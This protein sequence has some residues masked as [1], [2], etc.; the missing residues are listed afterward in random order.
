MY[1]VNA[2]GRTFN[3]KSYVEAKDIVCGIAVIATETLCR[4]LPQRLFRSPKT[5]AKVNAQRLATSNNLTNTRI[6][7]PKTAG[8]LQG[9][10]PGLRYTITRF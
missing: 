8:S 9:R 5:A 7:F 1:Q 6:T 3:A 4:P 10:A 2:N